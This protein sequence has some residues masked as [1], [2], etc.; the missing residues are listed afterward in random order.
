MAGEQGRDVYAVPGYPSDPRAAGPNKLIQDGAI[1][2]TNTDDIIKN[3]NNFGNQT[4]C[5]TDCDIESEKIREIILQ[6]ISQLPVGVDELARS[7]HLSLPAIQMAALELE[8]AGRLQ[9]LSGNRIV[10]L[11]E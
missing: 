4:N 10:L 9:R 7:C 5:E 3:I 6:N 1:L 11:D 8:L 2:V